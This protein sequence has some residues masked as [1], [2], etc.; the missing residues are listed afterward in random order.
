MEFTLTTLGT[1]SAHPNVYRYPSAHVFNIHGRL[2]LVDC[3]E[4]AQV[5]LC[6]CGISFSKIDNIFISHLHGD[7]VFGIF[8][9]LST[10]SLLGRTAELFIYAP[11]D[12]ASILAFFLSHFGEG[13]KFEIHHEVL[14]Y[15]E[16][17][18]IFESK[19]VEIS[20]FP[21]N[22]RIDTYGFLFKEKEPQPNIIKW[23]IEPNQLTLREMA[24][25][26]QGGDVTRDNGEI[27][28]CEDYTYIPYIGRSAA[29]CFDTAPFAKLPQWIKGVD[30]LFMEATF[31]ENM[32]EMAK[33]TNHSTAKQ[34]A[35]IAVEAG[36]GKLVIGH[37]SSRYKD[38]NVLLDEAKEIFPNTFLANEGMVFEVPLKKLNDTNE[39]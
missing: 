11:K 12:F 3:G 27:L 16:P 19:S 31:A 38:L 35:G 29:Y 20:T 36:A 15:K 26:K 37:Y 2:F 17:T 18:K 5:Q 10:M 9:L 32:A 21:L 28:K 39:E 24:Q 25:F 33:A 14:D 4:G 34:T 7:H 22:H 13:V 1:A 30:L 23:K 6:R 8:G